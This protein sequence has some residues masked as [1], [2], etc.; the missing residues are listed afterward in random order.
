MH[1]LRLTLDVLWLDSDEMLE[2]RLAMSGAGYAAYEEVYLNSDTVTLFAKQLTAFSG[3][4]RE[5]VVLEAGSMEPN[6]YNWLRLHAH[7]TDSVG[8]CVLHF[9]SIRRGAPVVAHHFDFSLPVDV[10][11]L[12]DLGMQLSSWT[13]VTGSTFTFEAQCDQVR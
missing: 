8:H 2:I 3:S 10:A 1:T 7:A 5:E 11:A 12:N 9:S 4:A 6:A 13:L